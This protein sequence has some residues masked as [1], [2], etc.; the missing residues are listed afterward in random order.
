MRVKHTFAGLEIEPVSVEDSLGR[1]RALA[2][3]H[4]LSVYDACYMDLAMR[5]GLPLATVDDRLAEAA[6]TAGVTR[7]GA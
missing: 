1:V 7:L 3:A 2:A 4:G 5:L 6:R